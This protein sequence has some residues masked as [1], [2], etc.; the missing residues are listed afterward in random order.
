MTRNKFIMLKQCLRCNNAS[1]IMLIV[2]LQDCKEP[3]V[4][5][6]VPILLKGPNVEGLV[7]MLLKRPGAV[8]S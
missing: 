4:E 3:N 7:P 5:G 2:K 8:V 6:L 1:D